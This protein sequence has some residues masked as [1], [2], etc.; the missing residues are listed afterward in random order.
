MGVGLLALL[1]LFPLGALSM[2]QAVKDD[3]AGAIAEQAMV[4]SKAGE[5]LVLRT[6]D[7]VQESL[8]K[9]AVDLDVAARLDEEYE[10]LALDATF[11]ERQLEDLQ[12]SLPPQYVQ[13]H[14]A[15][16]LAQIEVIQRRIRVV[17]RLF[18]LVDRSN[19]HP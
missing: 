1:T 7:F 10:Q 15:P 19:L 18:A 4:F 14:T 2:A 6:Q 5:D 9:G 16:L 11:I 8:L 17:R 13:P 12:S 3:R